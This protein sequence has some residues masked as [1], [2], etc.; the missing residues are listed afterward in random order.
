MVVKGQI[1]IFDEQGKADSRATVVVRDGLW[2]TIHSRGH[3]DGYLA[4]S[5]V[6]AEETRQ[7]SLMLF[8]VSGR[9]EEEE[10]V[11]QIGEERTVPVGGV[12]PINYYT[13]KAPLCTGA[14]PSPLRARFQVR[15]VELWSFP[16]IRP[17]PDALKYFAPEELQIEYG[18]SGNGICCLMCG[19]RTV[20]A[21]QVQCDGMSC[22][23]GG[24][25]DY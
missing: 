5:P 8:E 25:W 10:C 19:S 22:N 4:L 7:P 17:L 24:G 13:P 9:P 14:H 11:Q 15:G 16:D 2:A 21:N 3:R 6:I 1:T 12:F 23:G 20:C 18:V